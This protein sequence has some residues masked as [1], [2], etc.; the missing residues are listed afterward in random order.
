MD[1]LVSPTVTACPQARDGRRVQ[2]LG[3]AENW[4]KCAERAHASH[5][6]LKKDRSCSRMILLLRLILRAPMTASQNQH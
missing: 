1:T 5:D 6:E 4:V 3:V 2:C